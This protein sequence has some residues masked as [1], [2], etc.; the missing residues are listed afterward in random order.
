MPRLAYNEE[1]KGLFER[2][3]QALDG[4]SLKKWADINGF[5]YNRL[6]VQYYQ[7]KMPNPFDI[8]RY[9]NALGVT[10]DWLVFGHEPTEEEKKLKKLEN[11][12]ERLDIAL[13]LMDA[14]EV[15]LEMI[16]RVLYPRE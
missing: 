6:Q 13:A 16:R 3:K 2:F 14:D 10:V 15:T 1:L 7:K 9:A 5:D 12:R 4:R 11:D 8:V